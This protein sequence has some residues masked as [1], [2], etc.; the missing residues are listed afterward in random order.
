[1]EI[2]KV[3]FEELEKN[4]NWKKAIV[5]FTEDTWTRK[6]TEEQ[7]SYEISRDNKYFNPM[8]I[9]NSLFGSCIDGTDSNVRLDIYMSQVAKPW[10]VEYCYIV[11]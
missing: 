6:Y 3:S 5:V 8:M 7:R 4:T 1:M 11:E 10:H 9:G 2:E